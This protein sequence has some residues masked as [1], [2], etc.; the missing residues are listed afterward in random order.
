MKDEK[1]YQEHIASVLDF[2]KKGINFRDI[3]LTLEDPEAFSNA[4]N[5]LS[6]I[7]KKYD[8]NK[9]MCADARGFIFGAPLAFNT[10]KSLVIARKPNKLPRPGESFSYSLEY[11]DNTLVISE[12]SISKGD[13]VLI[14]DDLLATGGSSIAMMKIAQKLGA[15]P[16]AALFY[17]ELIDLKGKDA[18]K[19]TAPIDVVSLVKYEGE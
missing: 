16:V 7:A 17:I 4:I 18:I 2:P 6:E 8:F 13:R 3:T 12:G 1:Y 14:V 10:K 9:I 11:G 19:K 5:D 15:T